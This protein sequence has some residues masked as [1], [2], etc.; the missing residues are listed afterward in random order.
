MFGPSS[1]FEAETGF[2]DR[3]RTV[4]DNRG[5]QKTSDEMLET[6]TIAE[7][8]RRGQFAEIVR[9]VATLT[10]QEQRD[11][12]RN[13]DFA[14]R[15][16]Y[17]VYKIGFEDLFAKACS[18]VAMASQ[19]DKQK[20]RVLGAILENR[21]QDAA[22]VLAGLADDAPQSLSEDSMFL[23]EVYRH[24]LAHIPARV[25]GAFLSQR[26]SQMAQ[27]AFEDQYALAANIA[28]EAWR[29]CDDP[30]TLLIYSR[31]LAQSCRPETAL[32]PAEK[33]SLL[34]PGSPDPQFE[35]LQA[36][37]R[38][39]RDRSYLLAPGWLRLADNYREFGW[40]L[41]SRML[42][43]KMYTARIK[44]KAR[45]LRTANGLFSNVLSVLR[46]VER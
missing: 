20:L 2:E 41:R 7:L 1:P 26:L 11:A 19:S 34:I 6:P 40:A 31:A 44:S 45:A 28:S 33:A 22:T 35:R 5:R 43:H 32:E 46:N 42:Y 29:E 3:L 15:Y 13:P 23:S 18:S 4:R 38:V 37:A 16:L 12:L 8:Q 39:D 10:A 30:Y 17:A 24:E 21:S 25:S 36:V 14:Y 9:A 27:Y